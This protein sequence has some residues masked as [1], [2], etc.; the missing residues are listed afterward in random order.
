[1]NRSGLLHYSLWPDAALLDALQTD[2]EGAFTEIYKRYCYRLFTVAYRKL[3][4][5]EVAEEL[6]QDL[7][8]TIW[9]KRAEGQIQNLE[10]Y[11]FTALRYRIINY[12]KSQRVQTGYELYCRV[13]QSDATQNTE[14]QLA[15]QDL[16]TAL[17]AGLDRLPEKSREVFRLS[18]LEH[19]TVPEISGRLQLSEK[20][21]EYHITKS[22]KLLRGYLQDF[23]LVTWPLLLW[24][25]KI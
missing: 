22:L 6:V 9:T 23:L 7:F 12:V 10:A 18:R 25:T 15:Q 21:I 19:H 2:N 8:A 5:R 14:E 20:A 13:A 11:L 1:M 3:K 17:Q 16:D 24:I 4:S